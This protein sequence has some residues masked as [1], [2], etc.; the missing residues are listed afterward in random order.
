MDMGGFTDDVDDNRGAASLPWSID[1]LGRASKIEDKFATVYHK[2]MQV[3]EDQ[4]GF[5][6]PVFPYV[7][8]TSLGT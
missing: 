7:S 4:E 6:G 5:K 3:T 1:V 2:A 8:V